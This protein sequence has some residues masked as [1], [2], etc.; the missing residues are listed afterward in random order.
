MGEACIAHGLAAWFDLSFAQPGDEQSES[1]TEA[2]NTDDAHPLR[3]PSPAKTACHTMTTSPFA[4]LTH[5]AQVR[6]VM[7]EPLALN[8]G[9]RVEGTLHFRANESRSYDIDA[10]LHVVDTTLERTAH[11][12]LDKQTY[13]WD[14]ATA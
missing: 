2:D 5:W 7:Q 12:K 10:R 1:D 9:Q 14:A 13:Q 4:P 11:W 8:C 3:M 6:F